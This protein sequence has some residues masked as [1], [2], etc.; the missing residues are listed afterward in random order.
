[1]TKKGNTMNR[2]AAVKAMLHKYNDLY[3]N[4]SYYR[5]HVVFSR[6]G[7]D[8]KEMAATVDKARKESHGSYADAIE[9][10]QI[11]IEGAVFVNGVNCGYIV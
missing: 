8:L 9:M 5:E 11:N 2:M 7:A 6:W 10:A 3:S 4:T 1:M